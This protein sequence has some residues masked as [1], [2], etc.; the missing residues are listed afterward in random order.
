VVQKQG[1][2]VQKGSVNLLIGPFI[3]NFVNKQHCV[4]K[5]E[6]KNSITTV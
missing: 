6:I 2:L 5:K 3:K 1:G 4:V